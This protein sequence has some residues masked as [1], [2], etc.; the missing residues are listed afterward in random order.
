MFCEHEAYEKSLKIKDMRRKKLYLARKM[1]L[2]NFL[3]YY[4]IAD[5]VA[6]DCFKRG[7]H[8]KVK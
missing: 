6:E 4:K 5:V 3:D 7:K 8:V 1:R 2:R